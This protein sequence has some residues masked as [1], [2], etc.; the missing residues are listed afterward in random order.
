LTGLAFCKLKAVS[1]D[2]TV[3][4]SIGSSPFDLTG[5]MADFSGSLV[6]ATNTNIRLLTGTTG[7]ALATF[8]LGTGTGNITVR[9][10]LPAIALGALKGGPNTLL[11]GQSNDNQPVTFTIGGNDQDCTFSG[12]IR[13]GTSGSSAVTSVT[14]TGSGTLT[15]AGTSNYTGATLVN[16][17]T[18]R[19]TGTLGATAVTVANGG[20]LTGTGTIGGSVVVQ[21]G[22]SINSG[23]GGAGTLAIGGGLTLND[24]TLSFDLNNSPT[25]AAASTTS[26]PSAARSP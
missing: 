20:S 6:L 19:V 26:T 3:N 22:G 17:G 25:P 21:A 16:E 13:N 15:L 5:N 2:G 11:L 1:G 12:G 23:S 10:N 14:K 9:N 24:T 18:L 8:D 4:V 7:S